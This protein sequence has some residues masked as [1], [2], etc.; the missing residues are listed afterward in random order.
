MTK[1]EEYLDIIPGTIWHSILKT[2]WN[3]K[4]YKRRWSEEKYPFSLRIGKNEDNKLNGI[5][6]DIENKEKEK[7][8]LIDEEN[9]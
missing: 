9:K 1:L 2:D 7:G 8:G 5:L 3:D 4:D 6:D